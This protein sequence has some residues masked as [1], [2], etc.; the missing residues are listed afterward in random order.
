[1]VW[2]PTLESSV[3]WVLTGEGQSTLS[4]C[5]K[6]GGRYGH[7]A[8]DTF[9][10]Y[11]S[12]VLC[13]NVG[14]YSLVSIWDPLPQTGNSRCNSE[15]FREKGREVN[16]ILPSSTYVHKAAG[17]CANNY[18]HYFL[19]SVYINCLHNESPQLGGLEQQKLALSQ[20]RRPEFWDQGVGRF[21]SSEALRG[22][23][24]CASVLDSGGCWPSLG[25]NCITPTLPLPSHGLLSASLCLRLPSPFS[26]EDTHHWV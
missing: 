23:L 3:W 20:L 19:L 8:P 26:Y 22:N 2:V 7:L 25:C 9:V 21:G 5:G 13:L 6:S 16:G 17:L 15:A 24:F 11:L 12:R 1:M 4:P 14:V 10:L 18:S